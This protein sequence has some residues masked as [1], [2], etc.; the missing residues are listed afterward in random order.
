MRLPTP[1]VLTDHLAEL[2]FI[3][4][5]IS[6]FARGAKGKGIDRMAAGLPQLYK[7]KLIPFNTRY[8]NTPGGQTGPLV[9]TLESYSKL[10]GLVVGQWGDCSKDLHS[11]VKVL[12][13]QNMK[14]CFYEAKFV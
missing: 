5:G 13:E 2:K 7:R 11:L 10:E 3:S 1:E 4:A 8:H 12:G 6:C 9:R 14:H